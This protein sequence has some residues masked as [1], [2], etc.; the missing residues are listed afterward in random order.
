M[1]DICDLYI[2]E[3]KNISFLKIDVEGYEK[4]VLL[5]ADFDL[6]RPSIV[7]V[8]ATE[9]CTSIPNY[10]EWEYILIEHSYHFI[11]MQGVNR[12]YIADERNELDEEF[13]EMEYYKFL[14]N[15][16]HAICQK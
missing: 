14:Y 12:Y 4:E 15:I 5:G 16:Y 3:K 11:F 13:L 8:E 2:D 10:K 9:P 1:K 7:I 6:Y